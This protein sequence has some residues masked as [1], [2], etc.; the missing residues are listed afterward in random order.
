[1][2]SI[3]IFAATRWEMNAV[4][5]AFAVEAERQ[6]SGRRCFVG[7]KGSAEIRLVQTGIGLE[8]AQAVGQAVMASDAFSLV[9][10][11]GF[12]CA[13]SPA[14]VGDV[15]IGTEV[16][17]PHGA[18]NGRVAIPCSL[19][20]Q[21]A[22]LQAASA[23]NLRA[24][25]GRFASVSEILWKADQKKQMASSTGAI[26]LDMES[27]ALA[28]VAAA[29]AI[30]FVAIRTVSDLVDEDLPL[31][32]NLFLTSASWYQ[33]VMACARRPISLVGIY[34]LRSQSRIASTRLTA[35]LEHFLAALESATVIP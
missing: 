6:V 1:M 19:P 3:G 7:R 33:G 17:T 15:L 31:N 23:A 26:A 35:V 8:K 2:K 21:R 30:P 25:S 29:R 11:T 4:R 32:F 24:E 14:R 12:A 10:S 5:K 13:L 16:V 9:I 20:H 34:R 22:A 18:A 28:A 27:A